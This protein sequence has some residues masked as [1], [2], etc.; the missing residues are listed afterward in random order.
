MKKYFLILLFLFIL[1]FSFA[2]DYERNFDVNQLPIT[3]IQPFQIHANI[4]STI[5]LIP[6]KDW[7]SVNRTYRFVGNDTLNINV[8]IHIPADATV[9]DY[10]EFI[11]ITT[12][13]NTSS[14]LSFYISIYEGAMLT[15]K[16]DLKIITQDFYNNNFLSD[17]RLRLSFNNTVLDGMTN[18]QGFYLFEDLEKHCWDLTITKEGYKIES[19]II[20]AVEPLEERTFYLINESVDITTLPLD[21]QIEFQMKFLNLQIQYLESLRRREPEKIYI[22]QTEYKVIPLSF[23]SFSKLLQCDTGN[24]QRLEESWEACESHAEYLTNQTNILRS[25]FESCNLKLSN[26]TAYCESEIKDIKK[27]TVNWKWLIGLIII[28]IIIFLYLF[29]KKYYREGRVGGV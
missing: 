5:T 3:I 12:S 26:T 4:G 9:G 14:R 1:P 13:Y 19:R 17:A 6:T 24:L 21:E 28:I 2:Y 27:K 23:E 29:L 25:D 11:N 7:F 10:V 8:T 18:N 22:N 15:G 16:S 20:C